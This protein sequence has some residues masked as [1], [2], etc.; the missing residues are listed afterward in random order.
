MFIGRLR[1][2]PSRRWADVYFDLVARLVTE[3]GCDHDDPRLVAS[4]PNNHWYLPITI[5][6]R[7]VIS[8][9]RPQRYRQVLL[10]YGPEYEGQADMR[11]IF[12]QVWRYKPLSWARESIETP[13]MIA[14]DDIFSILSDENLSA[15]W[16]YACKL[17]MKR[18]RRSPFK[19][20][21][22]PIVLQ[23][24]FNRPLRESLLAEAFPP[25]SPEP[26]RETSGH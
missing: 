14:V 4:L 12:P 6:Y 16:L 2:A 24:A 11:E 26:A 10:I 7:Y 15:G 3:I 9:E 21:H 1:A 22:Y 5:N 18:V 25:A 8:A 17:E 13:F 19:K 23:A 20:F